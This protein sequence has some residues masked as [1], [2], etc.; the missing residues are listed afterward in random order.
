ML[1][2]TVGCDQLVNKIS[3]MYYHPVLKMEIKLTRNRK[4]KAKE[5]KEY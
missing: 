1:T 5:V 2:D 3:G 4:I